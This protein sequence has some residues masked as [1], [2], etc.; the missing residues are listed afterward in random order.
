MTYE[1]LDEF[2]TDTAAE[3]RDSFESRFGKELGTHDEQSIC[4]HLWFIL[5]TEIDAVSK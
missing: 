4:D 1:Q 5:W 2:V 3:V